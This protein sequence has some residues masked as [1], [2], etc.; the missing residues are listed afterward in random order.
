LAATGPN[1]DVQIVAHSRDATSP[2]SVITVLI[3]NVGNVPV[4][5]PKPFTPLMTPDDHLMNNF[6]Q[7]TSNGVQARFIGRA[8]RISP[9]NP[10][11]Y[12]SRLDPG[13]SAS[14]DT[15]LAM[16]YDLSAGGVFEVRY[17]QGFSTKYSQNEFGEIISDSHDQLSEVA[18]IWVRAK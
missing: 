13:Q 10:D 7:V 16:D 15:D 18:Q 17:E 12:F 9:D 3:R 2:S 1:I 5:L 4:Y 11:H 6:F 8:I 14:H